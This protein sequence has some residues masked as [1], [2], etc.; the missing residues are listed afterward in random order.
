MVN[1]LRR[2]CVDS[3]VARK[4]ASPQPRKQRDT[5]HFFLS[6][7]HCHK[8]SAECATELIKIDHAGRPAIAAV[9]R[10]AN[11]VPNSNLSC[12][13]LTNRIFSSSPKE[14]VGR[15][16]VRSQLKRANKILYFQA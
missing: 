5:L 12:P 15:L 6:S 2:L 4:V 16:V 11:L 1:N 10:I 8:Q 3:F 14:R 13:F 9:Q 7:S